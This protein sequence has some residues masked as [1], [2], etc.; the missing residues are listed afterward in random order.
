MARTRSTR[1]HRVKEELIERLQSGFCRPGNHFASN[2][3]LVHRYQISYQTA[4]RLIREL[5]EEGFLHRVPSSGTYVAGDSRPP[6]GVALVFHPNTELDTFGGILLAQLSKRL[7]EEAIPYEHV[8][9]VVF[10]DYVPG[11]YNVIWG[12]EYDVRRLPSQLHYSLMIDGLPEEGVN[13]TFTDSIFIDYAEVGRMGGRLLRKRCGAS[14]VAVLAGQEDNGIYHKQLSGFREVFPDAHVVYQSDW[15]YWAALA[16]V[17]SLRGLDFDGFYSVGDSGVLALQNTF[18]P[19]V[20]VVA[21]GDGPQLKAAGVEG[22]SIPWDQIMDEVVRLYRLR[23]GGSTE[24]GHQRIIRPTGPS[25]TESA[26]D[27]AS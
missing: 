27:Q 12:Q 21:Y 5:E 20:P 18:G 22:V 15:S 24:V 1:I 17:K 4:H 13:A 6:E 10:D 9:G 25:A 11:R 23:S 14:R 7:E 26:F 19:E 16:S 2:R 8:S 3:E